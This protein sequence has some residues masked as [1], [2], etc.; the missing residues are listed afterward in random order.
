ME[1]IGKITNIRKQFYSVEVTIE[2]ISE[3]DKIIKTYTFGN[4]ENVSQEGFLTFLQTEIRNLNGLYQNAVKLNDL[5]QIEVK[6]D[7]DIK[8][9]I[10]EV[11]K[12]KL[13]V[14]ILEPI[15]E[16]QIKNLNSNK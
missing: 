11:S 3:E 6:H 8:K 13:E 1:Y 14:D 9:I 10:E 5:M 15:K 4:S 7:D 16:S 12:G 2:F